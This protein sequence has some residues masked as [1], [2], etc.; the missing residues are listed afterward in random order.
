[1][2]TVVVTGATLVLA[3]PGGHRDPDHLHE[4]VYR[5]GVASNRPYAFWIFGS[6]V[7][8]LLAAGVP[9]AWLALRALGAGE[10]V[11]VALFSVVMVSAVL[12]FTKAETER[13]YLFL[14]PFLCLAAATT[15]PRRYLTPVLG[16]LAVQAIATELLFETV[17]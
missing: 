9:L 2:S 17:W 16:L 13:I 4:I 5:E 10:T 12:G 14:V 3:A 8:F 6:P 15:L 7:A 1:V 11:A